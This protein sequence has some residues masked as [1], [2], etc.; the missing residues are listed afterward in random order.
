MSKSLSICVST[1]FTKRL[2][3]GR[4]PHVTIGPELR[5]ARERDGCLPGLPVRG[6]AQW[7]IAPKVATLG[8][9]VIKDALTTQPCPTHNWRT[10]ARPGNVPGTGYPVRQMSCAHGRAWRE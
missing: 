8:R 5:A 3:R 7:R 1:R 2:I 4:S 6:R 10:S 9:G